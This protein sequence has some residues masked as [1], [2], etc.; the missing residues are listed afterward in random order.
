NYPTWTDER[1]TFQLG[2]LTKTGNIVV[3]VAG[4]NS[5]NG[6]PFMVRAGKIYFVATNG[7]D[8]N[9]GTYQ[10][11]WQTIANA[12]NSMSRGDT[13]YIGAGVVQAAEDSFTAYLSMDRNGRG[14]SGAAN[15]PKSLV[16]Y[17]GAKVQIGVARGLAYGVRTPNIKIDTD[18][19]LFSQLHIV[20][21][22]QA[23]D[24]SGTGWKIVG[25]K[26]EGPGADGEGGCGGLGRAG[27]E[28]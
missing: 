14:N 27:P 4:G 7:K 18:Y 15:A 8:S 6:L 5:S 11:P 2:P 22:T 10:S 21:G 19:W 25:N 9:R 28:Q 1:I 16:A 12:K 3:S 13:T 26:V 17:P 23:M 24:I 20:G